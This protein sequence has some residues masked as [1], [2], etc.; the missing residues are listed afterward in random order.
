MLKKEQIPPHLRF[1]NF[2]SLI[3]LIENLDMTHI[4][5]QGETLPFPL[6]LAFYLVMG[7]FHIYKNLKKGTLLGA[8][9]DFVKL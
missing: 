1:K 3:F 5:Y 7:K 8:M 6:V 4:Q 2:V 9:E